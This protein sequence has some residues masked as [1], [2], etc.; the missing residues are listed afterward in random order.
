VKIAVYAIAK[1]EAANVEGWYESAKEADEIVLLD[2]G[3]TDDTFEL[4]KSLGI[5]TDQVIIDPWRFDHARN[6]ALELVS[7]DIDFCIALDLDERLQP[8]WREAF[9]KVNP[10]TTRIKY[11][12][13]Y[14]SDDEKIM[15][16]W[17]NRCHHRQKYFWQYAIHEQPTRFGK[18]VTQLLNFD[19]HHI[20][21]EDKTR[22][23]LEML[24]EYT[25]LYPLIARYSLMYAKELLHQEYYDEAFEEFN[26]YFTLDDERKN[27]DYADIYRW[28]SMCKKDRLEYLL[29][30]LKYSARRETYVDIANHYNDRNM[31][32]EALKYFDLAFVITEYPVDFTSFQYAWGEL[33]FG[34]ASMAA[35]N[36]QQYDR[37]ER[38]IEEGLRHY[39]DSE[40]LANN[41]KLIE[42]NQML[43]MV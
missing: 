35:M 11:H 32:E 27:V 9:K 12:M 31:W 33:P 30:S 21:D 42:I 6:K 20:P 7:D 19:V 36:L 34:V 41:R 4:S 40:R 43:S 29:K 8:N 17:A 1:N 39:P 23:Y 38:Y 14:F 2:T 10:L 15:W 5:K 22:N 16:Y 18:E 3:S 25:E 26:R 37:A 13:T 28:M 24:K